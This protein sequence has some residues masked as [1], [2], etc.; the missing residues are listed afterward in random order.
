M[1]DWKD[2]R[3]KDIMKKVDYMFLVYSKGRN[4]GC[5]LHIYKQ[6]VDTVFIKAP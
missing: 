1:K 6:E 5:L 3:E 2:K 4:N